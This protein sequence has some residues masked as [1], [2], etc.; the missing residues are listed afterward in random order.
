[1]LL[2]S[3]VF[4]LADADCVGEMFDETWA[5]P[6][7]DGYRWLTAWLGQSLVGFAC[8]GAEALTQGTWDLFW[9]CVLP[10]YRGQGIGR[11]LLE[12]VLVDAQRESAR[13]MVIY[14]SSTP[15]YAPAR[16]LYEAAGF[17][18]V[19]RVPEYYRPGDD[20]CIYWRRLG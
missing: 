14:T 20:L 8:Y 1:M 13:L 5:K 9:I 10:N 12:A 11:A 18:C 2:H 4:G 7:P 17:V 16:S 15:A 6:R 3:E 19:A